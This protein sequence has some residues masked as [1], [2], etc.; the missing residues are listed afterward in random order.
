MNN[1]LQQCCSVLVRQESQPH[2][3]DGK[4]PATVR[5][6]VCLAQEKAAVAT[7]IFH[8]THFPTAL[9]PLMLLLL[10]RC[11]L[12]RYATQSFASQLT[13]PIIT[14]GSCLRSN[15]S[16]AVAKPKPVPSYFFL[17]LF[18]NKTIHSLLSL[19]FGVTGQRRKPLFRPSSIL[20]MLKNKNGALPK[21]LYQTLLRGGE[22]NNWS[23]ALH[24]SC[25]LCVSQRCTQSDGGMMAAMY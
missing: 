1:S 12:Q 8:V 23:D 16:F 21:C 18:S 15:C 5:S 2:S 11:S 24:Y 7:L 13:V 10:M 19:V 4:H 22:P 17:F 14:H 25:C 6:S 9:P 3:E 20:G